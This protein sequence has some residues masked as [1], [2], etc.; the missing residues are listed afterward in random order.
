MTWTLLL[1]FLMQPERPV[2]VIPGFETQTICALQGE[3]LAGQNSTL[4]K[5]VGD[6]YAYCSPMGEGIFAPLETK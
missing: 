6:V 3:L 1:V 2:V 5:K 4:S